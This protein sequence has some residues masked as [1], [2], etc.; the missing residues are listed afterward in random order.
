LEKGGGREGGEGEKKA[1][2]GRATITAETYW[3]FGGG[4]RKKTILDE[5]DLLTRDQNSELQ[6]TRIESNWTCLKH[7]VVGEK[8]PTQSLSE[9]TGEKKENPSNGGGKRQSTGVKET[10]FMKNSEK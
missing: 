7:Q 1:P 4:S 9:T 5:G 10:N 8:Y 2:M 3:G 6:S